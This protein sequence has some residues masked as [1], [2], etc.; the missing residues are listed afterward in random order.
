MKTYNIKVNGKDYKIDIES[1]HD[2][3]ADVLCNDKRYEILFEEEKSKT[4][5]PFISRKPAV[6][7]SSGVSKTNRQSSD[8]TA[9]VIKA[10]IPGLITE[11]LVKI[12]D[13]VK[14]GDVVA[15]ME[16]MKMENNILASSDGKIKNVSIKVGDSV[17]EGDALIELEEA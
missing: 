7:V 17:L 8:V 12:G 16:A 3:Q 10:P 11:V 6:P 1:I 13:T 4:K 2:N 14:G 5:T 9:N 15:K